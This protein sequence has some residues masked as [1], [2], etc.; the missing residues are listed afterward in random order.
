[1]VPQWVWIR[2]WLHSLN[3]KF[4][5]LSHYMMKCPQSFTRANAIYIQFSAK[6][7]PKSPVNPSLLYLFSTHTHTHTETHTHTHTQ[8]H[9]HIH[10]NTHTHTA[11]HTHTHTHTA[12]HTH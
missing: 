4:R 11:T 2:S 9:T 1:M 12:T 7:D 3:R 8:Q 6:L 10:S 5:E